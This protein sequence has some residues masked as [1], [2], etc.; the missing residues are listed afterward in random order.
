MMRLKVVHFPTAGNR[1]MKLQAP[2]SPLRIS[3]SRGSGF[4]HSQ[5]IAHRGGLQRPADEADP[6]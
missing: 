2:D 5:P 6:M 3:E 1:T 4:C